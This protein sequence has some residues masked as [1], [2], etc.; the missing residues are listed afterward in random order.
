M[1]II[2][3]GGRT[4]EFNQP[5]VMGIL[6]ST[7]DSF[8]AGSRI[9]STD[10]AVRKAAEMLE[11]GADFLDIGA[12]SSRQGAEDI[13]EKEE[14]AR[15]LPVVKAIV[16]KFPKVIIS[17]DTFRSGVAEQAVDA[18]AHI[19]NDIS[20]G[21]L[22]AK[23]I[24]T[25]ARLKVPYVFMHTKGTPQNMKDLAVYENVVTDVLEYLRQKTKQLKDAGIENI[26]LD[27]GFGFAK[28][29]EHNY[30]L[31]NKLE[32][33]QSL[34]LPVLAGM[35]RKSMIWKVLGISNNEA[36][37]GTTVLNTVALMKGADI[38]RVH[39]VRAAVEAVQLVEKLKKTAS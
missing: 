31:L 25:V 32:D 16:K 11:Q 24:G 22:D 13:S 15:L 3:I 38:L 30:Q 18:G 37:N 28:T 27:P 21:D 39:D 7:P 2:K 26:I 20:A 33:F 17:I 29:I 36:L 9:A 6:N 8:Y 35:S 14:T 23:M 4:V 19:I 34:N 1:K 12:Y 10:Q 5:K